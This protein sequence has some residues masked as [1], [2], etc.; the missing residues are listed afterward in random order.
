V[1]KPVTP[2]TAKGERTRQRLL[3]AAEEEFGE[4]GFHNASISNITRRAGVAQGTFYIYFA[5]KE[6]ILRALVEHMSQ[7]LRR[8][9]SEAVRDCA[10]RIEAERTGFREFLRF[11]LTHKNLYRIVMQ[12]QFIDPEI[13]REYYERLL[14]GYQRHIAEAQARGEVRAGDP[15]A[16]AWALIGMT[17]FFGKRYA[18]WEGRFPEDSVVET[19]LDFIEAGLRPPP[20]DGDT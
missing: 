15:G 6:S 18:T 10:D 2:V 8:S 12:S 16:L 1:A 11:A 4:R 19:V 20:N 3:E 17:Y 5:S 13:H 9:Q 14:R 7:E